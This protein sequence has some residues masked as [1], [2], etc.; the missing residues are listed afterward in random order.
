MIRTL[1]SPEFAD[2]YVPLV[3]ICFGQ[4]INASFGSVGSLLNMTGH[5]KDTTKSIFVG[6]TVNVLLN[7]LLTPTWGPIGA[8]TAT[9]V[10]LIVWNVIMWQKVRSRIGIEPTP[11]LSLKRDRDDAA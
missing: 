7:L 3:I 6:A 4:L 2:S 11:F 5:E 1:Y 8:A 9:T 10:T